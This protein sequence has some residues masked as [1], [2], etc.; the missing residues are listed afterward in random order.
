MKKPLMF[1]GVTLLL[2]LAATLAGAADLTGKFGVTGRLGFQVPADSELT[3]GGPI[4]N[5][6]TDVGFVGGGGFLYGISKNVAAEFDIT[7]SSFT[8]NSIDFNV[9]NLSFGAQYRFREI[10]G[11]TP[12]VGAG[13]D[14]LLNSADRSLDVDSNVGGHLSGGVD[15]FLM[16]NLAL[17][18]ELKF[19]LAPNSDITYG[20]AKL[21]NFDPSSF[22]M[23]FGVRYFIN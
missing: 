17:T 20:G 23:T 15:Y 11:F 7:N 8:G 2:A 19:V 6:S 21:G 3:T 4:H 12:Y 14:I 22:S 13:L 1:S 18:T 16:K 5:I 9:T 10:S